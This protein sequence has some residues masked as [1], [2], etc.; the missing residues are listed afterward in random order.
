MGPIFKPSDYIKCKTNKILF[1]VNIINKFISSYDGGNISKGNI[2]DYTKID[3]RFVVPRY[4]WGATSGKMLTILSAILS[5]PSS[6]FK[7]TQ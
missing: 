4:S 1:K 3:K 6:T 7:Y 2:F 5:D